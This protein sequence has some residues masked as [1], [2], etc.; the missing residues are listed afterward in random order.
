MH[1]LLQFW[2]VIE[3]MATLTGELS[4]FEPLLVGDESSWVDTPMR[5]EAS[6]RRRVCA[7]TLE[8]HHTKPYVSLYRT[9]GEDPSSRL[10]QGSLVTANV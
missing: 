2:N 1:N 3:T 8:A 7:S 6:Y 5:I 10:V 4:V 9:S